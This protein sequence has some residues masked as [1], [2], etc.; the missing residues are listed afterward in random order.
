[1][2]DSEFNQSFDRSFDDN[3]DGELDEAVDGADDFDDDDGDWVGGIDTRGLSR[4]VLDGIMGTHYEMLVSLSGQVAD[5]GDPDDIF[6]GHDLLHAFAEEIYAIEDSEYMTLTARD[7]RRVAGP[8]LAEMADVLEQYLNGSRLL[9]DVG[10][11]MTELF[12]ELVPCIPTALAHYRSRMRGVEE[13]LAEHPEVT[14]AMDDETNQSTLGPFE[15]IEALHNWME[16]LDD[17]ERDDLRDRF[18]ADPEFVVREALQRA[19][20]A[21]ELDEGLPGELG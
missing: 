3:P 15:L 9:D 5:G 6:D 20:L 10:D 16:S 13:W 4:T 19:A 12:R 11:A 17:D 14:S 8:V 1:M 7:R 18:D 2:H 21:R